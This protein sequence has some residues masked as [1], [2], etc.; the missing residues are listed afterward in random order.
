M[1]HYIIAKFKP[2]VTREQKAAMLPEIAALFGHLTQIEGIRGVDVCPNCVD[3]GNRF[4]L[5]IEIDMEK[6][7]LAAYDDCVWHRQWK[8]Q[9]GTLLAQ[10][11]IFDRA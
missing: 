6:E 7:A 4:D 2:E 9:Y 11:T 1:K 8:E 3:R 5:M 10:K